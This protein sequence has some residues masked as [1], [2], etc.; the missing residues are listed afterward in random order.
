MIVLVKNPVKIQNINV[1]WQIVNLAVHA[2]KELSG[3]EKNVLKKINANARKEIY[4]MVKVRDGMLV[5]VSDASARVVKKYA[6]NTVHSQKM[7]VRRK[8][9]NS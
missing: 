9:K 2:E 1:I 3:M 8:V 6:L 5:S 7:I 4:F